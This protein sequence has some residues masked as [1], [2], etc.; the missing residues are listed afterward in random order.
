MPLFG[1][2]LHRQLMQCYH[3]V[4]ADMESARGHIAAQGAQADELHQDRSTT[5]VSLAQYYLPEL[6]PEAIEKTWSEIRN[7]VRQVLLRKQEHQNRIEIRFQELTQ[8]QSEQEALLEQ[9]DARL[10]EL[11]EQQQS[12]SQQLAQQLAG[13]AAFSQLAD[14]A[15]SAEAALEQAEGRLSEVQEDAEQKLPAYRQSSLFQYLYQRG[16]GT[17]GYQGTGITRRMDRWVGKLIGY[18]QARKSYEFLR[19]TPPQMEAIVRADR[20]ALETVLEELERQRDRAARAI[21]LTSLSDQIQLARSEREKLLSALDKTRVQ[22]DRLRTELTELEDTRGPYYREAVDLFRSMLEQTEDRALS[23]HA[24]E[25]PEVRDDQIVARLQG[26]ASDI[27]QIGEEVSQRQQQIRELDGQLQEMGR[28]IQQFR[29]AGYESRRSQFSGSLD[30]VGAIHN[31][32][33]GLMAIDAVWV[34]IRRA[35][36]FGPTAMEQIS[37][38]AASPLTQVLVHAMATAAGSAL[39]EHA[40]RAGSRRVSSSRRRGNSRREEDSEDS[41]D[42]YR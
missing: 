22:T 33:R 24:R 34:Q 14:R 42:E 15:A 32:R 23:A 27:E 21:G 20:E 39:G 1:P 30:L 8:Q 2:D 6:T 29:A 11:L 28:L 12:L 31:Y 25:T 18:Q 13:D 40:R 5:L 4:Q 17:G 35:Q 36:Q 38:V 9:A 41:E 10:D 19:D 7:D 37:Q 3:A 26:L 16:L